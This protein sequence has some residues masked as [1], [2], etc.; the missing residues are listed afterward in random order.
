MN[1]DVVALALLGE[2][3]GVGDHLRPGG[4]R[5]GHEILAV[6]ERLRIRVQRCSAEHALPG[7]G[8]DRTG[9]RA[10]GHRG[11]VGPLP[12]QD[13]PGGRQLGRARLGRGGER[14]RSSGK[15]YQLSVGVLPLELPQPAI[16]APVASTAAT[17][18]AGLRLR[19][20]PP[21]ALATIF[22]TVP[23]YPPQL[24]G[25]GMASVPDRKIAFRL[26]PPPLPLTLTLV[27]A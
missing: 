11:C 12:G 20:A 23:D 26:P 7:G 5:G 14:T 6:P 9:E 2:R 8:A 24:A 17:R 13:P 25:T 16:S 18:A 1:F 27:G 19:A 3:L 10:V 21:S 15:L 22:T 4:R